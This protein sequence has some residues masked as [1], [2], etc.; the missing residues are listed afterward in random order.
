MTKRR[1]F[2]QAS[3]V[4]FANHPPLPR[5]QRPRPRLQ[6]H[7]PLSLPPSPPPA[8]IGGCVGV[9][10]P[11]EGVLGTLTLGFAFWKRP[12]VVRLG[13]ER[14]PLQGM[15]GPGGCN[16][17]PSH[18][19]GGPWVRWGE[20]PLPRLGGAPADR[21]ASPP[22]RVG[23]VLPAL[24]HAGQRCLQPASGHPWGE[25][26]ALSPGEPVSPGE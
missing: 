24:L 22:R 10:V 2:T 18:V 3:L 21:A 23:P 8:E 16:C 17:C 11:G 4:V 14:D 25:S 26:S 7:R 5:G 12:V 19:R 15:G 1:E 20:W 9:S 13:G 6:S